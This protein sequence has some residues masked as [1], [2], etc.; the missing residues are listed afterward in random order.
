[1]LR[2]GRAGFFVLI[3]NVI[4]LKEKGKLPPAFI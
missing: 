4:S 3:E 1:M 2:T